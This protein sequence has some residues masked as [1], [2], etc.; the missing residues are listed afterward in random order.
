MVR[1]SLVLVAL[2]GVLAACSSQSFDSTPTNF[3]GSYTINLTNDANACALGNWEVGKSTPSLPFTVTQAA[4]GQDINGTLGGGAG[5]YLKV[6][7][8]TDTLTGSAAV[9]SF[10][11]STTT[12]DLQDAQEQ[13]CKYRLIVKAEGTQTAKDAIAG[14][15]TYSVIS[16]TGT[17]TTKTVGCKSVQKFNGSRPPT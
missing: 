14:T 6:V 3:A 4:G 15:I 11:M 7:T 5:I 10:T 9:G 16:V 2:A 8:G 13:T 1:R 17:C 12:N